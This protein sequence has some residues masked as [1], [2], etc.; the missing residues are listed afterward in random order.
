MPPQGTSHFVL[1]AL[2]TKTPIESAAEVFKLRYTLLTQGWTLPAF[3]ASENLRV[4]RDQFR[5]LV[6]S[7]DNI[8][9][10]VRVVRK[11]E[12][13]DLAWNASQIYGRCILRL[14]DSILSKQKHSHLKLIL[15]TDGTLTKKDLGFVIQIVKA[16]IKRRN[17]PFHFYIEPALYEPNLQISDSVAWT[18]FQKFER[19][20]EID[21]PILQH[22]GA[23]WI[24]DRLG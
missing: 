16:E 24:N 8:H 9:F 14:L 21:L 22:R 10:D 7:L 20:K 2:A 23:L 4:I 11:E 15:I 1:C 6:D 13:K 17:L 19:G 3:H 5:Q 18:I 12:V